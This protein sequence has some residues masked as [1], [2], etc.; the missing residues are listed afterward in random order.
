MGY[1]PEQEQVQDIP[2]ERGKAEGRKARKKEARHHARR[3]DEED[4]WGD[5]WDDRE[6]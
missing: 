6:G 3:R 5:G 4:E 2:R 1:V